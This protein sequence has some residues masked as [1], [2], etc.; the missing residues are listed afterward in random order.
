MLEYIIPYS[1][2]AV[3]LGYLIFTNSQSAPSPQSTPTTNLNPMHTDNTP[4]NNSQTLGGKNKKSKNKKT[5][6]TKRKK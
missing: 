3:S 1:M 4:P 2:V 5:L 6:K